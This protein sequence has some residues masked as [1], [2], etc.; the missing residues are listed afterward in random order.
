MT[1]LLKKVQ[2]VA[3]TDASVLLT[4][5]NGTGKEL[6]AR[7]IHRLSHRYKHD[8]VSIDLGALPE[9][10]IESELFGHA[11]GAFTDA[12]EERIGRFETANGGTL[13]L[14]E[15]GNLGYSMQPKLLTAIEQRKVT[16]LGTNRENRVDIRIIS[17]TNKDLPSMV[18]QESSG[19][20]CYTGSTPYR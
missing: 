17:A 3:R 10:L 1:D 20:T 8:F 18:K 11:K 7:E 16:P 15:I 19:K 4:G 12:R 2:K 14:D 6:I 13:F 9:T 5:E